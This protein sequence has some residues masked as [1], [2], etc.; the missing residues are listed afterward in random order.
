MAQPAL[1]AACGQPCLGGRQPP[2]TSANF[3]LRLDNHDVNAAAS[4]GIE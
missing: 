2:Y 3:T 1:T 4:S